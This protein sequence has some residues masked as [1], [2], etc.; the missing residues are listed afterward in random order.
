MRRFV[1]A[2]AVAVAAFGENSASGQAAAT[3]AEPARKPAGRPNIVI[4]LVDNLGYGDLG[5]YG[6]GAVRG[7]PTPRID[8]FARE[9][10][11]FTNFNVES[12]CTPTRAALLTGRMSVRSGTSVVAQPGRPGGLSTWEY[13]LAELLSDAGY[14]TAAFGKWHLGSAPGRTAIEQGFDEWFGIPDSSI[15]TVGELQPGY[16]AAVTRMQGVFEGRRGESLRRV[17][18]Y[19]LAE[20]ALIDGKITDRAVAYIAANA[21][22]DRPFFL[23]VPLTQP[24]S[25]PLPNPEFKKP[26]KSD[27]QNALMEI[28][29]N[30]GRIFD[31]LQATG[32][33]DDTIVIWASDNGPETMSGIGV[34][35]GGQSDSGPFRGEFPGAWEGAVRT[36]CI[37][38]WPG[39]VPAGRVSN[40]IVS[41][42]DFYRTLASM[43]G[44]ADRMPTDRAIDSVDI[45]G[46]LLGQSVRSQRE[47]VL[48]FYNQDLL[49]V[50]WRNYKIHY[51]VHEG[52]RDTVRVPGQTSL[53]AVAHKL[54]L[55]WVFDIENDPKELWNINAANTWLSVPVTG[56]LSAYQQSVA[57]FPNIAPGSAGPE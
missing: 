23:Y 16:D 13:T 28:D 3:K 52:S 50:K 19:D 34:Q 56:V 2:L 20:R 1:F 12:E 41:V 21:G 49:A 55:P 54:Y 39:R 30:S 38:R 10:F 18:D 26:G 46:L 42:L 8:Q 31:A 45:S 47:S 5:A 25:P 35:Y 29:A 36:P 32:V 9:G 17:G 4:I 37:V 7:A 43:A 44:A 40:E 48:Y 15:E 24:H 33:A 51:V 14:R 57:M 27:F 6:G 22:G 53:T 11:R